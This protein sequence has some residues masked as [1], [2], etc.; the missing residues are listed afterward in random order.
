MLLAKVAVDP[1][2]DTP[3]DGP[4]RS[5]TPSMAVA[6]SVKPE[7]LLSNCPVNSEI[8][9]RERANASSSYSFGKLACFKN[10]RF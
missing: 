7:E 8:L 1:S 5:S 9:S 2:R 3:E 4:R 6:I 10:D